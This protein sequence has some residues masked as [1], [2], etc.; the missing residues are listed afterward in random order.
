LPSFPATSGRERGRSHSQFPLNRTTS[1]LV[2]S[3]ESIAEAAALSRQPTDPRELLLGR[4]ESQGGDLI[5]GQRRKT[6]SQTKNPAQGGGRMLVQHRS[7]GAGTRRLGFHPPWAGSGEGGV[8]PFVAETR[9]PHGS[10]QG[11]EC[12]CDTAGCAERVG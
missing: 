12:F 6:G 2:P 5:A 7:T 9:T 4:L 8:V 10:R 3:G 1:L 11:E